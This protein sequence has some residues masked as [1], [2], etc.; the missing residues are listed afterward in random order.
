MGLTVT[1]YDD[2]MK[3]FFLRGIVKS[4]DDKLYTTVKP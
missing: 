2:I 4:K 1:K 3:A